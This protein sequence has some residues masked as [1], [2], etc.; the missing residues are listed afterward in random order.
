MDDDEDVADGAIV[1]A[2]EV[3]PLL[4]MTAE[5]KSLTIFLLWEGVVFHQLLSE[6]ARWLA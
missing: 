5:S 2:R 1:G 4:E 6:V 3:G